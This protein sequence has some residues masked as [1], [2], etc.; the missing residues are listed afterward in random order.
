MT[1]P[2]FYLSKSQ[3]DNDEVCQIPGYHV[4]FPSSFSSY[5]FSMGEW[6]D[7]RNKAHR[8]FRFCKGKQVSILT[9]I[10]FDKHVSWMCA[11]TCNLNIHGKLSKSNFPVLAKDILSISTPPP[12]ISRGE[13]ICAYKTCK[14]VPMDRDFKE[15]LLKWE[16]K[17]VLRMG[18]LSKTEKNKKKFKNHCSGLFV[19]FMVLQEVQVN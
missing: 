15:K 8:V 10:V 3:L 13:E 11:V 2:L 19:T 12:K 14:L 18:G 9:C 16:M 4:S 17:E 5:T 1:S 7:C 6:D